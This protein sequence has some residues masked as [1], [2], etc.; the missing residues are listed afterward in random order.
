[1]ALWVNNST[2]AAWVT[3]KARVPF[4]AWCSALKDLALP[5][6][7]HRSQ[8]WLPF[9][10]WPGNFLMP[11]G[12]TIKIYVCA[13]SSIFVSIGKIQSPFPGQIP[14]CLPKTTTEAQPWLYILI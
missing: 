8:L 10:L 9:S 12:V 4:L 11:M 14:V 6:L 3:A 7:Q 2:A 1:M 5:Q 13:T